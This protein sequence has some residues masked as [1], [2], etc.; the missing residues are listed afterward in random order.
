MLLGLIVYVAI[1]SCLGVI[2][3]KYRSENGGHELGHK[4]NEYWGMEEDN[5]KM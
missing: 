3:R 2:L 1:F 5:K 4:N